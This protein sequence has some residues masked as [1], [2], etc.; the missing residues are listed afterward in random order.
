MTKMIFFLQNIVETSLSRTFF[1]HE[2]ITVKRRTACL[3]KDKKLV[4]VTYFQFPVQDSKL[5]TSK[6]GWHFNFFRCFDWKHF[7]YVH[8][9]FLYR[10]LTKLQVM[11]FL[12]ISTTADISL[13]EGFCWNI[14]SNTTKCESDKKLLFRALLMADMEQLICADV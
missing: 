9:N 12:V 3:E 2:R 7:F 1:F 11:I 4:K 13:F 10:K 5:F 8:Q 6:F 14:M